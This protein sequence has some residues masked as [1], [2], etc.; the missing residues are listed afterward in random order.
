MLRPEDRRSLD[1][2]P[3]RAVVESLV[4]L[5]SRQN[6][7]WLLRSTEAMHLTQQPRPRW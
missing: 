4:A 6:L 2:A 1:R 3:S 7:A 5:G